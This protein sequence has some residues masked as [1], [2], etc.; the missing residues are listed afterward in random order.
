MAPEHCAPGG[1]EMAHHGD[2]A[3][4]MPSEKTIACHAACLRDDK[5][6]PK[7]AKG[8]GAA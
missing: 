2:D 4:A 8:D 6:S 5:H 1:M 3:P 7:R